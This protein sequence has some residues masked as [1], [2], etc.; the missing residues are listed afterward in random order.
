MII[1]INWNP[2]YHYNIITNVWKDFRYIN[3]TAKI[4]ATESTVQPTQS[5][6]EETKWKIKEIKWRT[7]KTK[8]RVEETKWR[9]EKR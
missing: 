8:W 2:C 7:K 9:V 6:V 1:N 5:T 4:G 3:W